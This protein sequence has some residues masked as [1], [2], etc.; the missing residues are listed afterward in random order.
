MRT[1]TD[2][3]VELMILQEEN[4]RL[5]KKVKELEKKNKNLFKRATKN[6]S[7]LDQF[8]GLEKPETD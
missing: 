5:K 2:I 7:Y 8:D 1:E 3:L 4:K 6:Y